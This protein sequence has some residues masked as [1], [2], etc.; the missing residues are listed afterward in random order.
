MSCIFLY[1]IVIPV[2]NV[3]GKILHRDTN[4]NGNI[5]AAIPVAVIFSFDYNPSRTDT[6][7]GFEYR[8][9]TFCKEKI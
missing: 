9:Y 8:P 3:H 4:S 2:E 6:L 5:L 7:F 1:D